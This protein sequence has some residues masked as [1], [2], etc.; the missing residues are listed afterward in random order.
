MLGFRVDPSLGRRDLDAV[1][2]ALERRLA[3]P[4]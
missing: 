4:G 2:F 3:W 1:A